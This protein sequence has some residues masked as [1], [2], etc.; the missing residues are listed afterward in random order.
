MLSKTIFIHI[1]NLKNNV[2]NKNQKWIKIKLTKW[3]I[4]IR[5]IARLRFQNSLSPDI[6]KTCQNV[7]IQIQ[8]G[9]DLSHDKNYIHK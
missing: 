3:E 7:K 1:K 5:Q 2:N 4:K 8:N 9:K 6:R